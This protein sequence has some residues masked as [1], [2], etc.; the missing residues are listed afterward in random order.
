MGRGYFVVEGQ[1]EDGAVPNLVNRLWYD[2]RLPPVV[3][4]AK[5][6]R[7]KAL[8]LER[9]VRQVCDLLRAK[10]DAGAAPC[11]VYPPPLA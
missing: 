10:P 6:L 3:W 5:P 2:L 4:N 8:N 7:G 11:A 9:G 1:G